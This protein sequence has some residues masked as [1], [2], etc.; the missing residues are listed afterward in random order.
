MKEFPIQDEYIQLC[1]LLKAASLTQ[2][3]GEAKHAVAEGRVK[4]NGATELRK[5][6]KTRPGDVVE[7]AGATLRVVGKA[8]DKEQ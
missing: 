3:G 8:P 4:V 5:R 1:D 2:S 7:F 6:Y